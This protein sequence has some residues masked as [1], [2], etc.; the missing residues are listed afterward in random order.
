MTPVLWQDYAADAFFGVVITFLVYVAWTEGPEL[1]RQAI[2]EVREW[3]EATDDMPDTP[4]LLRASNEQIRLH[5]L[6]TFADSRATD[7]KGT[8]LVRKLV[9]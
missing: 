6:L 2:L 5:A 1:V 7:A 9:R 3:L 4:A 8:P